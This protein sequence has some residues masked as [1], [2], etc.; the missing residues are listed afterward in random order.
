M[1]LL[2]VTPTLG[3]SPYLN[4]TI[5]SVRNLPGEVRH[6]IVCPMNKVA[7]IKAKYKFLK[8]IPEKKYGGMYAAI[9]SGIAYSK[10][11]FDFF[12][13]IND[14][15]YFLPSVKN[16]LNQMKNKPN[17]YFG[18]TKIVN[19]FGNFLYDAPTASHGVLCEEYLNCEIVPFMQSSMIFPISVIQKIGNFD[20]TY[21]YC[22][23]LEFISRAVKCGIKFI[24]V[25]SYI[26]AFRVHYGQLSSNRDAMEIEI[27]KLRELHEFKKRSMIR[28][29]LVKMHFVICNIKSYISRMIKVNKITSSQ[30]F[31]NEK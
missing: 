25:N 5:D 13:Y 15:D 27:Y 17:I 6:V 23:D 31:Y 19:S 10:G 29:F 9:N 14:D 12:C 30:V 24:K 4:Q 16:C 22:G 26:S 11:E 20:S 21:K 8:V 18:K 7:E 3:I 1:R 2:V 28:K